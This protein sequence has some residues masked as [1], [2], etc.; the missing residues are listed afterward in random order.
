MNATTHDTRLHALD[1]VR[2]F[3]L[4]LGVVLHAAMS[5]L[6]GFDA[7]PLADRSPS[8]TLGVTFFVIHVFR[9]TLFFVL[10]GFF[11]R[12]VFHRRGVRA[13]IRERA[14]RIV[15]PLVVG[16]VV[17]APMTIAAIVWG[18]APGRTFT[19]PPASAM[20]VLAFPLTH[21]WFLYVL[22]LLYTGTLAVRQGVV[23]RLDSGG[24]FRRRLDGLVRVLVTPLGPVAL[25]MPL[26]L[27]LL[28]IGSWRPE[29]GIPTPDNSLIP[30]LPAI[31]A[32][33]T[34]FAFGWLL[35]RQQSLLQS[36]QR[37]WPLHLTVAIGLTVACLRMTNASPAVDAV[38]T[39]TIP[40][41]LAC[42]TVAT[43]TWTFGLIGA[44]LRFC[45]APSATR[46]YVSDA[47][48]WVYL[49]HLP[50][51][52]FLQALVAQQPWH[53]TL[54]FP[55]VMGTALVFLFGTYHLFVRRSF[56]GVVLNGRRYGKATAATAAHADT[57]SRVVDGGF[58]RP[59]ARLSHVRKT[60]GAITALDGVSLEVRPGEILAVLGPNG[61][62]KSTAI[63][64]LLGLQEP[65][66]GTATL[67]DLPPD[68]IEARYPIGVMMQEAA[69]APELKV[70]ELIAL[71]CSYYPAPYTVDEV[72]AL[73][74][75][76]PIADRQ[77]QKLSGGQKRLAQFA[78]AVCGR[79]AL[80][81]LD[82]PT[83][84]L[85]A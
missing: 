40:L 31:T 61:A 32:F 29:G 74:R 35:Q 43:W 62:G 4:L 42:Y 49:A 81:F 71:T 52:F 26:A 72:L 27:A 16:W 48:Y 2:G 41:Y 33:G 66:D 30:N 47:S 15:V 25:A 70:R 84:G 63:A 28:A 73:T 7:W 13:F 76:A 11:A 24:G 57:E 23:E 39:S 14:T 50:V 78:L 10:A 53:W 34:A 36:Y 6:P 5:Y 55:L 85:D 80:L 68:R 51:V 22:V 37:W 3:A 56:I 54:K 59:I 65:T 77:Y 64:L 44:A 19:P 12:M 83:V 38:P 18:A 8:Q 67:F 58:S 9:M 20:P 79:P 21:L 69:L 45:S 60:F 82:E 75:T 17:F 1:A 46:R